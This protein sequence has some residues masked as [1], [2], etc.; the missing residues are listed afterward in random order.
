MYKDNRD[1]YWITSEFGGIAVLTSESLF[2]ERDSAILTEESGLANYEV[3][4]VIED[5][6]GLI[7]L[8]MHYGLNMLDQKTLEK[9]P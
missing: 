6:D 2:G 1:V 5:E 9:I 3:K 4:V 8:G 7:W